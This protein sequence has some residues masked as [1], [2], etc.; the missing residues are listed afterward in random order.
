MPTAPPSDE[1]TTWYVCDHL[2]E[3]GNKCGKRFASPM[4]LTVHKA[5]MHTVKDA[6]APERPI[7]GP[8]GDY[9]CDVEGCTFVASNAQGLQHH[10]TSKHKEIERPAST[11]TFPCT[12]KGCTKVFDTAQGLLMH[13]QR[14]HLKTCVKSGRR[15]VNAT[16]KINQRIKELYPDHSIKEIARELGLTFQTVNMRVYQFLKQGKLQC[17]LPRQ[18]RPS[19]ATKEEA[20]ATEPIYPMG[21]AI[22]KPLGEIVS[23][24]GPTE[25]TPDPFAGLAKLLA[26]LNAVPGIKVSITISLGVGQ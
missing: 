25:Y 12:E 2:D 26:K 24:E 5:M 10:K 23:V 9:P 6:T 7:R 3:Q 8:K 1:P 14:V 15:T 20:I 4:G 21:P 19:V 22:G 18:P 11:E 17:K 13:K 16:A